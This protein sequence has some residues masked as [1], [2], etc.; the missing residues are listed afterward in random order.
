MKKIFLVILALLLTFAFSAC[1]GEEEP[2]HD[3]NE[4]IEDFSL[5]AD[6]ITQ[7]GVAPTSSFRL[8]TPEGYTV[9][10]IE[11]MTTVSPEFTFTV[12]QD[13]EC[14]LLTP[15]EAL[16]DDTEY[17]F[18]FTGTSE[19]ISKSFS[20]NT[21][22]PFDIIGS[23]PE[24]EKE[25][26]IDTAIEL[27]FTA[28][29]GDVSE[30]L[31]IEPALTGTIRYIG[32]KAV[33][34]T[35]GN[36]AS[37]GVTYTVTLKK[38]APGLYGGETNQDYT[39][40][41]NVKNDYRHAAPFRIEHRGVEWLGSCSETFLPD[42]TPIIDIYYNDRSYYY[43]DGP[44]A[45]DGKK[46]NFNVEL[47]A[48]PTVDDYLFHIY[49]YRNESKFYYRD[50]FVDT[51]S[52]SKV[53]S[54]DSE[55]DFDSTFFKNN[56]YEFIVFPETVKQ[57]WYVAKV[58]CADPDTK[59]EI[60]L[61]T[62]IQV[63][64]I[65]YYKQTNNGEALLWLNNGITGEAVKNVSFDIKRMPFASV[66]DTAK[67]DENGVARFFLPEPYEDEERM[68]YKGDTTPKRLQPTL[69]DYAFYYVIDDNE[70][71][72]L[73]GT[74]ESNI[75]EEKSFTEKYSSFIYTDRTI[76]RQTDTIKIWGAI[77]P[78]D[79][80][81]AL[82]ELEVGIT[83]WNP[84]EAFLSMKVKVEDNGT[85]LATISIE[86][87]ESGNYALYITDP[88]KPMENRTYGDIKSQNINVL[89]YKKPDYTY[90]AKWD[91]DFYNYTDSAKA[92][93]NASFYD[94]TPASNMEFSFNSYL[95]GSWTG[96]N[97]VYLR[98]DKNG[99]LSKTVDLSAFDY[100]TLNSWRPVEIVYE[101]SNRGAED[102]YLYITSYAPVFPTDTMLTGEVTTEGDKCTLNANLNK[103]DLTKLTEFEDWA[104]DD[105]EIIRG[106]GLSRNVTLSLIHNYVKKTET[107]SYYDPYT[108]TS[109]PTYRYENIE[110]TLT[111][112]TVTADENGKVVFEDLPASTDEDSYRALIT[113]KDSR[114]IS[115]SES[116]YLGENEYRFSKRFYYGYTG[117]DNIYT[118][119][120]KTSV[121]EQSE[122]SYMDTLFNIGDEISFTLKKGSNNV[123]IPEKGAWMV[124]L[125]QKNVLQYSCAKNGNISIA[126]DNSVLPNFTAMGAYFDG[127]RI[128]TV[129][130][131]GCALNMDDKKLTIETT[132]N[133][134]SLLPG[135]ELVVTLTV[136]DK[137]NKPVN[138][139]DVCIG[140]VNE[141]V[142]A[143]SEQNVDVLNDLYG[144]V[145]FDYPMVTSSFVNRGEGNPDTA[146][147]KGGGGGGEGYI[148]KEFRDTADMLVNKTDANGKASFTIKMPDDLT[149]WRITAIALSEDFN[150]GNNKNEVVTT[151]PFFVRP[152]MGKYFLED[153]NVSLMLRSFGT[154][155]NNGD[156]VEY[157]F[158]IDDAPA[159]TINGTVGE[160]KSISLQKCT[161]GEHELIVTGK[162]K[163]KTDT[164]VLKFNV[165]ETALEGKVVKWFSLEEEN[166]DV[167]PTKFPVTVTLSNGDWEPFARA[168]SV[169]D[170]G[171]IRNDEV[172]AQRVAGK[173]LEEFYGGKAWLTQH[174]LEKPTIDDMSAQYDEGVGE[175]KLFPYASSD[176]IFTGRAAA[177]APE[178]WANSYRNAYTMIEKLRS[179]GNI[180]VPVDEFTNPDTSMLPGG[181]KP[182][183]YTER[184]ALIMGICAIT[185]NE[186][187][188]ELPKDFNLKDYNDNYIFD[189]E[190]IEAEIAELIMPTRAKL[191]MITALSYYDK[192]LAKT[193]CDELLSKI[194]LTDGDTKYV[195]AEGEDR[196]VTLT[197]AALLT[198]IKCD[199][200][201]DKNACM[202]YIA[203][204]Q[205]NVF[206]RG[207]SAL[208]AA[209]FMKTFEPKRSG[210]PLVSYT[211]NGKTQTAD[212]DKN[213][214][215]RLVLSKEDFEK[216]NFK[217]LSGT[218]TAE[219]SY[220]GTL[221]E[222]GLIK[223]EDM[224][225]TR[226]FVSETSGEGGITAV[227]YRIKFAP[228]AKAGTY[229][230]TDWIP[231]NV[232][233]KIN[234]NEQN[235]ISKKYGGKSYWSKF[236]MENQLLNGY[237]YWA[238][239]DGLTYTVVLTLQNAVDA[240]AALDSA[241][242]VNMDTMSTA[243]IEGG[244]FR[245]K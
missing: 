193:Y 165:I 189:R 152:I 31:S 210:A 10:E 71:N 18:T 162:C 32:N 58:N 135:E 88:N 132:T 65:T 138:N 56:G 164:A 60:A 133:K 93:M 61:Y 156:E 21:C 226:E 191:Y 106:E 87:M 175:L 215:C 203:E 38:G 237:F 218:A 221:E 59:E 51:T 96:N 92:V 113:F 141:A 207:D 67:T 117:E 202:L 13:E 154:G 190:L 195:P 131:K 83:N 149:S 134:E 57:G 22:P 216:A 219:V 4:G 33:Y 176:P 236:D 1:K 5:S 86:D 112:F 25:A 6:I 28:P 80:A 77:T 205:M 184:A 241:Y 124:N 212:L 17:N 244:S 128:Y 225:F 47:F 181:A 185:A 170:C 182:L 98:T 213:K 42:E 161:V 2:P 167:S 48:L 52:L 91:K 115:I 183:T 108:R 153:E 155:V 230:L 220:T 173:A 242:L 105:Y 158:A 206:T 43:G 243:V 15:N 104:K 204:K 229:R 8:T 211:L 194:M 41:F 233:A 121:I 199:S 140:V 196:A 150:A 74:V 111:T 169:L 145:F 223:A 166:I 227:I 180:G 238:P 127:R 45:N 198:A 208:E 143:I 151:L 107:G 64:P 146:G 122:D 99:E 90:E 136:K 126:T 174:F 103:I 95:T 14:F 62:L 163:G 89:Q 129:M 192:A 159:G 120:I 19:D 101:F 130:S 179:V 54:F 222:A 178:A 70:G 232:R 40:S 26:Y 16:L 30:Y 85:F 100:S 110:E 44:V 197:A 73:A 201:I 24:N 37:G 34:V 144:K 35:D 69:N 68:T 53:L 177:V 9:S 148:R 231:S 102:N 157:T 200:D 50:F 12:S 49:K 125:L 20:F 82:E 228:T 63:S 147:G 139:A 116:F 160:G 27:M 214:A 84:T 168:I 172:L 217:L 76:Y 11:S 75:K 36:K 3:I 23:F 114:G 209:L 188:G 81:P 239:T 235:S 186:N 123:E 78:R 66:D 240:E 7:T 137:N 234:D 109:Q 142:F 224:S 97:N 72:V 29:A 46:I 55:L 79:D 94:G 245:W 171:T 187:D 118:M 39:F 119:D